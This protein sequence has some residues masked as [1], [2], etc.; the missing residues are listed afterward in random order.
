MLGTI[1]ENRFIKCSMASSKAAQKK[2][3]SFYDSYSDKNV[4]SVQWK[5]NRVVYMGSNF[6]GVQPINAVKLCGRTLL[7]YNQ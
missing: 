5:D 7:V 3:R 4:I 6:A 1:R 2:E